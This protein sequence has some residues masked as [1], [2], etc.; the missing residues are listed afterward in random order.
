MFFSKLIEIT[1]T[2]PF[3]QKTYRFPEIVILKQQ[4]A[5]SVTSASFGVK[6]NSKDSNT[7]KIK[8]RLLNSPIIIRRYGS[9]FR[10]TVLAD[11]TFHNITVNL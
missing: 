8:H 1:C 10:S 2:N 9:H 3:R 4:N 6:C 11:I 5:K 7:L